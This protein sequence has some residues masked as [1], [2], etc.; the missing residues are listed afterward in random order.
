MWS[1]SSSEKID[2]E[3]KAVD[4]NQKSQPTEMNDQQQ[5]QPWKKSNRTAATGKDGVSVMPLSKKAVRH[6]NSF[7]N[8]ESLRNAN[9]GRL[10]DKDRRLIHIKPSQ[11]NEFIIENEDDELIQARRKRVDEDQNL[12]FQ[13]EDKNQ[14]GSRTE[15]IDQL[16]FIKGIINRLKEKSI[17]G[18]QNM[19]VM[20]NRIKIVLTNIPQNIN[21]KNTSTILLEKVYGNN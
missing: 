19:R 13:K 11:E 16:T 9:L 12:S 18:Y 15:W 14:N 5:K 20:S 6:I 10:R 7:E 8:A 2:R 1:K 21:S 4:T 17:D 3:M